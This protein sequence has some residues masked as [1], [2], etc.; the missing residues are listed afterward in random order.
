MAENES[1]DLKSPYAQRWNPVIDAARKGASSQQVGSIAKEKL[2]QAI[3]KTRK[4]LKEYGTSPADFLVD[5]GNPRALRK[6]LQRSKDHN[7]TEQLVLT[8]ASNPDASD[9]ECYREWLDRISDKIF[10]QILYRGRRIRPLP[11]LT[12]RSIILR[13]RS[14]GVGGRHR[15]H[16]NQVG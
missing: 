16:S 15:T 10:D 1:L 6:L 3:R 4:D 5:R 7:Y 9:C 2:Y 12:R 13:E 11:Q 8:L 14:E